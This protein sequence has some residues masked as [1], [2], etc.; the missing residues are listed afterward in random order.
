MFMK[1]FIISLFIILQGFSFV[2]KPFQVAEAST[3]QATASAILCQ[4]GIYMTDPQ[5]CVPLGPS[6]YLTQM[7]SVGISF[8]LTRLPS[9]PIDGQLG[10]L[11]YF[12]AVLG[13]GSSQVY[14]SLEDAISGKNSIGSIEGGGLRYV[15][16][17]DYADTENG[18]FFN[19][20][21]GTW[22]R[23][24]SRVSVPHSYPGGIELIR[25]PDTSFGWI[26]PF[27]PTQETKHTPGYAN[28][29]DYTG[30]ILNQ[31]QIV[32]VYSSQIVDDTE[33]YLV[34]PD[35]WIEGRFIG[36]VIPDTTPPDGVTN[37]RWIEVNLEEQTLAIY[38]QN[39]LVFATL[40]ASGLEPFFTKP[41]TF[42]IK[43]KLDS[44]TM[45]GA[46]TED[47]SDFY[48]LQDV[49]WT[50]YYDNARALHGAYWRTAF[51]FPQSHGCVNLAPSDA[52]WLYD[53]SNVGDWV[54][55][56]D[57]SGKTPTDPAYY[58][59]GGA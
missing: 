41:G 11:P 5:D 14:A 57:P 9:R 23:V 36:R 18:R 51:G 58:G 47:R 7:A 50:M 17:V 45:S 12:Y 43:N 27:G 13:D 53:W 25:T 29:E 44:T 59:E 6:S 46:F 19:L 48:Y 2:I 20:H 22:V 35:E 42:Q 33:W 24:G 10:E 39:Q 28:N 34:A 37:G 15:S 26:L 56:W 1:R 21:D 30:H 32:Q 54:Y 4:P 38:D 31:Y 55:V 52:R 3:E 40:I 16:Y 8:P 49:P